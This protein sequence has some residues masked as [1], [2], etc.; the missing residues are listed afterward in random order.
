MIF[1]QTTK[2]YHPLLVQSGS[3]EHYNTQ[4]ALPK[5]LNPSIHWW[6]SV[7]AINII[8]LNSFNSTIHCWCSLAAINIIV[9]KGF[10]PNH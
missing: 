7:T 10:Y 2:F 3:N 9:P 1:T 6:T 8:I 4:G 5:P